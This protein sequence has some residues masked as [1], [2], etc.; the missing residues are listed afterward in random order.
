MNENAQQLGLPPSSANNSLSFFGYGGYSSTQRDSPK[1]KPEPE[2]ESTEPNKRRPYKKR[3]PNAPKRPL[4]A[5]FLY[6]NYAR[7]VIKED[8]RGQFGRLPRP[9][10]VTEE[11][12]AR[13]KALGPEERAVRRAVLLLSHYHD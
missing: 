11:A 7:P 10:Q 2:P 1:P 9:K 8:L 5:Y 13:F 6:L 3:D 12:T 4:T